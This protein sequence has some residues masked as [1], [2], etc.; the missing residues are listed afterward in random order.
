MEVMS[1]YKQTDAG[2]IPDDWQVRELASLG[3]HGRP[4]IK[5]GPFGSSLTKDTYVSAGYKV[6]GQ[7]QVIRGDYQYGDYFISK[8]RYTELKSCAVQ[9]GDILLSLVGTA[10]RV[11]IIPKGAPEGI[12]NPRLIRFSFDPEQVSSDYFKSIIESDTY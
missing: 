10:G 4:V 11:L 2:I 9:V 8:Q 5:A 12:I 6:Y 3:K 7:E 1:G